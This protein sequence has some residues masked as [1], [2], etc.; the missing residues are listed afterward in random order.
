[1][2][3]IEVIAAA[4]IVVIAVS[5]ASVIGAA[6][7]GDLNLNGEPDRLVIVEQPAEVFET[8]SGVTLFPCET[9]D[10]DN[11]YWDAAEQGNRLGDSFIT[12]NGKTY[13]LR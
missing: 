6:L 10:S 5:A 11:C 1:M 9:E 7:A 12:F 3:T 13:Y 8:G 4:A 2:K